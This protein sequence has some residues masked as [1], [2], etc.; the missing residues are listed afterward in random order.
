MIK[1]TNETVGIS[2]NDYSKVE[3]EVYATKHEEFVS[4]AQ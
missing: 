1:H 4:N 3:N 2:I